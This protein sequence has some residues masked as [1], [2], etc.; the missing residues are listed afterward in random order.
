MNRD[1]LVVEDDPFHLQFIEDQL[2]DEAFDG[3][4]VECFDNGDKAFGW[5]KS[6]SAYCAIIDLNLPG[7]NGVEV[8]TRVWQREPSASIVFWSNFSDPAYA[9]AIARIVPESGNFGYIL[10]T[11][12]RESLKRSLK[13]VFFDGQRI[14]DGEVQGLINRRNTRR[15]H[16]TQ[17]ETEILNLIAIG[18]TDR[19]ISKLIGM[20]QRSIQAAAASIYDKFASEDFSSETINKRARLVALAIMN[21]EINRDSLVEQERI[22]SE[23]QSLTGPV[24]L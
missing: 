12:S 24:T 10:K 19:A 13:G 3:Y 15:D 14:I 11:M 23:H 1:L 2:A 7:T 22:C 8:A 18:L 9:R 21:G 6:H 5:L 20:S 4:R 16:L 17:V